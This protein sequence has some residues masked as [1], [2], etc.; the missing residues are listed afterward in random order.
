[1]LPDYI[2]SMGQHWVLLMLGRRN[3]RRAPQTPPL[4]RRLSPL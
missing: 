1:M 4:N 3:G 2:A